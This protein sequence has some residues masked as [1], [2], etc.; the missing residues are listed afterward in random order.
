MRLVWTLINYFI[1]ISNFN[2]FYNYNSSYDLDFFMGIM[3]TTFII[4]I[5]VIFQ[6]INKIFSN[7]KTNKTKYRFYS[8]NSQ[9]VI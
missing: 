3:L 7:R 5:V 4:T 8:E 6:D 9:K 2:N 1:I